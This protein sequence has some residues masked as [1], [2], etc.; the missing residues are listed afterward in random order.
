MTKKIFFLLFLAGCFT[1]FAQS[2]ID[3]KWKGTSESPNG[4]FEMNYNFKAEGNKLTGALITD[5][6]DTPIENGKIDG[7]KFSYTLSFNGDFV[8]NVTGEIISD[9]EILT[10]TD[11]GETKLKRVKS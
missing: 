9:D 3:G 11:M 8:I 7:K 5:F 4:V 10:K 6:G 1:S 2:K